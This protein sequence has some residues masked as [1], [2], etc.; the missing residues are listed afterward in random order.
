MK[1]EDFLNKITLCEDGNIRRLELI[2]QKYLHYS[3][4][5]GDGWMKLSRTY[6]NQV[7]NDFLNGKIYKSIYEALR[8]K[9]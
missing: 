1:L 2:E 5:L 9:R 3:I 8:A 4:P 7:E 6:R